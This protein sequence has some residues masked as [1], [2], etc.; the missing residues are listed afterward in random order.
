MGISNRM[1]CLLVALALG[2]S[3]QAGIAFAIKVK[4]DTTTQTAKIDTT[5][6]QKPNG[7][8]VKALP[9]KKETDYDRLMKDSGTV[10]KGL[11][12][13]RHIKDKWYFEMHDSLVGRYFMAVTR[14]AGVPQGFVKFSGEMVNEDAI[15]F[16]KRD[17][18]TM[19]LRTFVRTQEANEADRI[20]LSLKQSTADPIVAAFPIVAGNTQKG[21]NLFD[22]T[23]F[24]A[25]DNNIVGINRTFFEKSKIGGQQPDRTFVDTIK[26]YPINVE[27]LTTRTYGASPSNIRASGTGAITLALNTSIVALPKIP[28]RKRVWDNRVGFFAYPYTIFSD[29]QRKSQR[30]QFIS[31]FRLVPKDVKRYQRGELVEPVKP[32]VF[33]IDP[34]T[35]KRWVPYLIKGINDWNVAFEAAG[36]KNAIQGK[37]WPANDPTMSL[38]DARFNAIRYLPSEAE[39]AYGPHVK[40]P[41]SGEIIE[42]HICWFHNVTNLLTK[43]YMTQCGP[44]DKRARTMNFDDRLMG[45]LIRFV[46]S[47][48]VGHTL[49]LRHNM[50]ASYATPVEKLRDKAWV[51]KHGHTASIMDYAR[52]NYVAQPEDNIGE[53]GLFPHVNDYDK[54]AI[55]W[56]YQYRPEFKDELA[57]KEKLMV[58]TTAILAK[59][60]RLWF[61]GEGTNEDPRAQREDLGD[62]NVK[63]SDYGVK[64]LQRVIANL[65][66]WTRQANDQYDDLREMYNSARQQFSRY[67]GHVAKNIGGR[68]I[69]NMPGKMPYELMSAERQKAALDYFGRQV[70]DAPLWLYPAE[71]TSKT[72]VDATAEIAKMQ[73]VALNATFSLNLLNAIYNNSQASPAAYRLE[74]YLDDLFAKVWTPLD[75]SQELKNSSRRTLQR[76]YVER[77]NT[78]LNPDD[79][80]KV[81]TNAPAFNTDALLYVAQHLDKLDAYLKDQAQ[82]ATGINALHY[83]DLARQVRQIK[84]LRERGK[85]VR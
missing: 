45:E 75:A 20:Y 16:E 50:S 58:E 17:G 6:V 13:V 73:A 64:N 56:G 30:E 77:L 44:L 39:N 31:R 48:E 15:Y 54:W 60:P 63:A 71:I 52:F 78:M 46:S 66:K 2:Y 79:K 38:D 10:M 65:P 25:R 26:T 14:F 41:R 82:T 51:E 47:H 80:D 24:F 7:K 27:V 37:E 83:A 85:N 18:K 40:D 21:M 74:N 76:N 49:G 33:Y 55:K 84:T 5:K 61:G 57:E 1:G 53:R 4:K 43:W 12:T 22:V 19:L 34:A 32:I 59:N 9:K 8:E 72:G 42:S 36:F 3:A 67:F 81:G 68:Y 11:F 69:N 29:K 28:M 23:G 35:P 70:F 62:D